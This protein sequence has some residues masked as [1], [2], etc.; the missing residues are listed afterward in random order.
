MATHPHIDHILGFEPEMFA[1]IQIGAIW[2]SPILDPHHPQAG[3]THNL[4]AFVTQAIRQIVD[5]GLALGPELEMLAS[6]YSLKRDDL[7]KALHTHIPQHNG[8]QPHFV[9][10]GQT[11]TELGLHLP[12]GKITVVGPENDIDYY[13]LGDETAT[14][15]QGL[16]GFAQEIAAQASVKKAPQPKNISIRDFE[17]LQS[18]ML[19]D[20]FAFANL[21]SE[22]ENNCSVVLLLEWHGRRLL[23][24]GD[25]EWDEKFK[26]GKHNAAWNV[27]WNKRKALLNAPVDF[28]KIGHHGSVNATPWLGDEPATHE[29][30]QIL[31]AIL[32]LPTP[33]RQPK[34]LAVVSTQRG[35]YDVIPDT[36]LLV[37][38]GK[39]VKT[40][41]IY[42]GKLEIAGVILA[43]LPHYAD[44]E[45][46]NLNK[47]QPLRTDFEKLLD[48]DTLDNDYVDIQ[49]KPG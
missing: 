39:R 34:A 37:E 20:A 28:L 44:K 12:S 26:E 41:R 17:V 49:I 27:M 40:Q 22:V 18:R 19:S 2:L 13:Y 31:N 4:R 46:A 38:L 47:K 29:V 45:Q 3:R 43:E 21:S 33:G 24:V 42:K 23:F 11:S 8:I 32:P 1:N 10:A 25:A 9:S 30:N 14:R 48:T 7:E 15:L 5:K 35:R 36:N 16:Q 6:L